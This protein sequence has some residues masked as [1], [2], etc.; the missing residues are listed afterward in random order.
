MRYI[1][2]TNSLATG[3]LPRM[4]ETIL[5]ECYEFITSPVLLSAFFSWLIAQ[6]MKA[7]IELFKQR[8]EISRAIVVNLLWATGG[9]PSSHSSLVTALATSVAFVEGIGSPLFVVCLF[10]ATITIRD[11]V[12]V[13]RAAGS[14]AKVLNEL[15][16]E[17]HEKLD[18][19]ER[20]VKEIHGHTMAEVVAGILV[21]FVVAF[22]FCIVL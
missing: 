10:Y 11:A 1:Y 17:L 22:V 7:V 18:I 3:K 16:K 12:G 2:L 5:K 14:Q 15:G 21:G 4:L 20:K 9:M 13:R 8:S 19:P 6:L